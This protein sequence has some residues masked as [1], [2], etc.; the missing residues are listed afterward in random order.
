[1]YVQDYDETMPMSI[2]PTSSGIVTIYLLVDPYIKN[3]QVAVCPSAPTAMFLSQVVGYPA[4]N[5][6]LY[7]SYGANIGLFITN[8]FGGPI[9]GPPTLAAVPRVS[10]TIMTYDANVIEGPSRSRELIVQARHS[11]TFVANYLDGHA[12][13]IGATETKIQTP[14]L[15]V[16]PDGSLSNGPLLKVYAISA[17]GG[18]YQ[19]MNSC[20]G[21]PQE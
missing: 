3:K 9:V 4:P 13:S 11:G 15:R 7:T 8:G 10:D 21:F 2:Y 18:Y 20:F 17:Q 14:Q 6:P 16:N 12:K 19:G 1:M 5:T